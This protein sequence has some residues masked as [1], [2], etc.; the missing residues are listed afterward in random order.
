MRA[1]LPIA[2]LLVTLA[3]LLFVVVTRSGCNLSLAE[4]EK[5]NIV[6]VVVDTLRAGRMNLYGDEHANTP[7]LN[8]LALESTV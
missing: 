6:L 2:N 1:S 3:L 4:P 5:Y 8:E 7:F